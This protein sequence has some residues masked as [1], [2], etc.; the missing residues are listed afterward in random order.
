MI[1]DIFPRKYNN[2]YKEVPV[3]SD[4]HILVF[5]DKEVLVKLNDNSMEYPCYEEMKN[6]LQATRYLFAIDNELYFLGTISQDMTLPEGFTWENINIFRNPV[7]GYQAFAGITA[8]QLY[9]WYRDN[10]ICGRCG[11]PLEH[12]HA[13]RMLFC[14]EC[15]RPI[16]P[17][18]CPAVIVAISD[19]DKLLLT[20]YAAGNYKRYAL[21]AGFNEIGES[22]EETVHREVMEEVGLK[23]KN[24]R[25]YKSQPW[26]FS[27]TLLFGFFAEVDGSNAIKM[28]REELSVA[29][30]VDRADVPFGDAEISLT[31][32]MMTV[33]HDGGFDT[34]EV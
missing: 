20:K 14:K 23:V 11:N 10:R 17:Q 19:G 33:F 4:S 15:N 1:Q 6:E 27:G 12:S 22:I 29:E 32:E 24:L 21:V 34:V 28:D 18:I 3:K 25:Y 2:T 8:H 5:H 31:R 16:Y 7:Y 13:E 9:G 26:S 30:W